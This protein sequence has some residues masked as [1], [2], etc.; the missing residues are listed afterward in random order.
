MSGSDSLVRQLVA[1]SLVLLVSTLGCSRPPNEGN[2]SRPDPNAQS[3]GERLARV[4]REYDAQG[5][6][7]T[8]TDVDTASAHWLAA[9][10]GE[11]GHEPQL[12]ALDFERTDTVQAFVEITE[13]DGSTSRHEGIPLIDSLESTDEH[14]ING[15]LGPPGSD[16]DIVVARWPPIVQYLPLFHEVRTSPEVRGLVVVTGGA[17]LDLPPG[18]Q[19]L[20]AYPPGYALINAD[21]Y[22]EP[23]GHPVLQLPS[24]AGPQLVAA[25]ERGAKARLVVDLTRVSK[26]VF[27][28]T[29][30]VSG[31][32]AEAAPI[33]VM[34]PRSGWWQVASERG[35]GLALWVELLHALSAE[36]PRRT[37]HFVASTGH[38]L[39]HVGLDHY[40]Q[41]RRDLIESAHLWLHLGANFAAAVGGNIRL[42]ASSQTLMERALAAMSSEGIEPGVQTP[43]SD[44]PYG[45][46][47][48][49][50]DGGG[51]F[52]SLLGSNGL[53]HHPDDRWPESVDMA[54]LEKLA[55]AFVALTLEIASE[56]DGSS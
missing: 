35:G 7:R 10:V 3:R 45:E 6:H 12:G 29:V 18:S 43:V 13:E 5:V 37:V 32:D 46:A 15:T 31:R 23:Y 20:P 49:I 52:L 17:E 33:V 26:R 54:V 48:E 9:L 36:P 19:P 11:A 14:G 22:L 51:S 53:F 42:Q 4:I 16:A 8:G 24:D 55:N 41:S 28:V 39:G 40:L 1:A 25:R 21:R 56:E 34:T 30:T 2:V 44:R 27:N 38:E 47:R 50:F